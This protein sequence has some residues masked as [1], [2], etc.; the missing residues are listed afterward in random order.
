MSE[1]VSFVT[2]PCVIFSYATPLGQSLKPPPSCLFSVSLCVFLSIYGA[3]ITDK[4][5]RHVNKIQG[6]GSVDRHCALNGFGAAAIQRQS[7]ISPS[8]SSPIFSTTLKK[9]ALKTI[10]RA[11]HLARYQSVL[12]QRITVHTVTVSGIQR[13]RQARL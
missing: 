2:F 6:F 8:P 4:K 11:I 9:R 7:L 1:V 5:F 10:I 3:F 12:P 13:T